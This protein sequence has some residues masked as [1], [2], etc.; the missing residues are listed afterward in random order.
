MFHPKSWLLHS[1]CCWQPGI[2]NYI[3]GLIGLIGLDGS[4]QQLLPVRPTQYHPAAAAVLLQFSLAPLFPVHTNSQ[5]LSLSGSDL[6]RIAHNLL[7][8]F[9]CCPIAQCGKVQRLLCL[10]C[11]VLDH[12]YS[13]WRHRRMTKRRLPRSIRRG[14]Y[15]YR[16]IIHERWYCGISDICLTEMLIISSYWTAVEGTCARY[17][18]R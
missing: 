2:I 18:V 5:C 10:Q 12:E 1:C 16:Y 6:W 11:Y 13:R 3:N 17:N 4:W 15:H 14:V 8:S 9:S 7:F